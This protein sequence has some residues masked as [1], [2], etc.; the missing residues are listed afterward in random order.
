MLTK[1]V[2]GAFGS[3]PD[4]EAQI[5]RSIESRHQRRDAYKI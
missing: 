4:V 5:R 1:M 2:A 3:V